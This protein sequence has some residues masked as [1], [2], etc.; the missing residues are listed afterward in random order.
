[1]FDTIVWATDGSENADLALEY[2]KRLSGGKGRVV[3]VHVRELLTGRAGGYPLRVDQNELDDKIRR[4]IEELRETGA[5]ADL[6]IATAAAGGAAHIVADAAKDAGADVI[7]VGT[8]G[9]GPVA[10]LL[11]GS[12]THRLLQVAPC[13]VL[14]VPPSDRDAG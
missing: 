5:G 1:M 11:L 9:L 2:V 3:A 12:V 10:G 13:P 4:Q 14:V 6:Q 7:V 8:R